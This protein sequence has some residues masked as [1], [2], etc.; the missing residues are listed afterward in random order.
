MGRYLAIDWDRAEARLVWAQARGRRLV[1][2]KVLSLPIPADSISGFP[3]LDGVIDDG[4]HSLVS[5]RVLG[6]LRT[7][8]ALRRSLVELKPLRLPPSPPEDLPEL[9]RF[10]AARDFQSLA[11][12]GLFDYVSLAGDESHPR[13]VLAAVVI[14]QRVA[15]LKESLAAAGAQARRMVLRPCAAVSLLL[16]QLGTPTGELRMLVDFLQG[17]I[18]MTVFSLSQVVFLRS[19][20]WPATDDGEDELDGRDGLRGRMLEVEIRRT[21]TAARNQSGQGAIEGIYLWRDGSRSARWTSWLGGRL[22]FPVREIDPCRA[23]SLEFLGEPPSAELAARCAPLLGLLLD[24]AQRIDPVVDFLRVQGRRPVLQ[25]MLPIAG[26]AAAV[27]LLMAIAVV[28]AWNHKRRM[29][30]EIADASAQLAR[31][32]KMLEPLKTT[33]KNAEPLVRWAGTDIVWLD[34]IRNLAEKLPSAE[35]L[36]LEE[37]RLSADAAAGTLAIDGRADSAETVSQLEQAIRDTRRRVDPQVSQ[38]DKANPQYPWSFKSSLSVRGAS[39]E[40]LTRRTTQKAEPANRASRTQGASSSPPS[41]ERGDHGTRARRRRLAS[42]KVVSEPRA[43]AAQKSGAE[44]K[45]SPADG[46]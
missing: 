36:L 37:V 21:L 44:P 11:E 14:D 40:E 46:R 35:K 43:N 25:R 41:N 6:R 7:V 30:T 3:S 1:V 20:P 38:Q 15:A 13:E 12:G 27:V 9:V 32:D 28:S 29:D 22:P 10:Q 5:N 33:A 24:D 26:L 45:Q 16:R 31:I 17:E 42:E 8:V 39:F 2:E 18:E 4:S 23:A 19:V 34:E